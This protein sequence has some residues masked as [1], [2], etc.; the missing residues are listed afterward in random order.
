MSIDEITTAAPA[1][2]PPAPTRRWSPRA[3]WAAAIVA[4]VV[5]GLVTAG[6]LVKLPYYTLSPGSS[7][8]TEPLISVSGAET[9]D[10][11]GNVDYLTVSLRE[12]TPVELLAAWINPAVDVRS[13]D[14][15]LGTQSPEENRQ[16]NLQMMSDSKDAA[17][18]QALHRLGYDI[19]TTGSGAV[20][21]QVADGSP[22]SGNLYVGDVITSINGQP[23]SLNSD[24]VEAIGAQPPG[25]TLTMEAT[26]LD[27][28]ELNAITGDAAVGRPAPGEARTVEVTLGAREDDPSKG[29]LGISTF[30]RDLNFDFPVQV[31]IDSGRVG[32]PSAGLAFTLGLLDVLTPE[33]IT[34]GLKIATTGTMGLDGA[35]GPVGGVH[36]KV[37]AAKRE[38]VELM[39]VPSSELEEARRYADGLRIEPVD[40]LDQA[41]EVLAS[42][43]GGDAVLP[44]EPATAAA[45]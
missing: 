20:V 39:L 16:V 14:E 9:Y 44:A 19:P 3:R 42:V 10:S 5:V 34:G 40:T 23:I 13:R 1:E 4:L 37:V 2:E 30:T 25:T 32:G 26:M 24:L 33:S 22:A 36:Q 29:F 8:A 18:Y 6:L 21:A 31:T 17:T 7:R 15:I 45:G 38:G 11:P 12:S 43:G 41:L 27:L 28:P 35:V